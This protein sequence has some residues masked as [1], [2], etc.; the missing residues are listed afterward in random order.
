MKVKKELETSE[1]ISVPAI[2]EFPLALECKV[3]YTQ[4]QDKEKILKDIMEKHSP[5]D[6]DNSNPFE[7]KAYYMVYYEQI[8]KAYV[9][10]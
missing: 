9:L 1:V 8:V 2:K 5:Q 7:N 4:M 6:V 3:I 10:E